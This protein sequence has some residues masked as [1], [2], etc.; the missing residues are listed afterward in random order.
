MRAETF[1]PAGRLLLYLL[2]TVWP[3]EER[4]LGSLV[5]RRW[6]HTYIRRDGPGLDAKRYDD[7]GVVCYE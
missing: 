3:A 7:A 2:L 5:L 4:I 6:L 1:P